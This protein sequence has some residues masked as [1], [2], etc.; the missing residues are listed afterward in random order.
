MTNYIAD[1]LRSALA[2]IE[3]PERWTKGAYNRDAIGQEYVS[4]KEAAQ[5][6]TEGACLHV[7]LRYGEKA[8]AAAYGA[9]SAAIET[10]VLAPWNDAPERTH[11]EVVDAFRRAIAI[12]EGGI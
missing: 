10:E 8:L 1:L 5:W 12:A 9:L 2:L 4:Y 7:E 3:Q 11:G 6:C